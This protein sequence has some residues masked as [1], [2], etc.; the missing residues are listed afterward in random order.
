[1]K[2]RIIKNLLLFLIF[3]GLGFITHALFFPDVLV[4]GF[5]DIQNLVIPNISP[6]PG[7]DTNDNFQTTITY[8]GKHFSRHS[9]VLPFESYIIIKNTSQ[10]SLMWLISNNPL[11][12][13]PRGYA[14][15]EELH[16]RMDKRGTFLVEDK[17]NPQERLVITVK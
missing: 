2:L 5:S 9:L 6:T 4:N 10:N 16:V 8:D 1:M 7:Q 3:F 14:Y 17:S 13:T 12:A 11:L 15:T